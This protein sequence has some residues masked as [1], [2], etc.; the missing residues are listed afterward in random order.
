[1]EIFIERLKELRIEKKLSQTQLAKETGL[2]Q[3][4]IATWEVGK[5]VPGAL[6]IIALAKYFSVSSDYLLGL[7]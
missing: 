2:T 7:E 5:R 3:A 6:A 4:A 1:M